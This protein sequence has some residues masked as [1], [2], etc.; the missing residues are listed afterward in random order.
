M[1]VNM[2]LFCVHFS[3]FLTVLVVP[4]FSSDHRR[5]SNEIDFVACKYA[6]SRPHSWRNCITIAKLT[7][8][9]M[10]FAHK[11]ISFYG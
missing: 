6:S 2:N 7:T 4:A 1:I 11:I 5:V 8:G 9:F 10:I 3:Q